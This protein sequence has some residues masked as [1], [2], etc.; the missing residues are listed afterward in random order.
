MPI[1]EYNI[2][3]EYINSKLNVFEKY[4]IEHLGPGNYI[5]IEKSGAF[6]IRNIET[7]F[8]IKATISDISE[9]EMNMIPKA[10]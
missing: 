4:S 7:N 10:Y 2:E 1:I 3:S 6:L 5:I 9:F 8:R